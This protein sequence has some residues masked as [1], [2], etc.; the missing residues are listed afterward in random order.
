MI[1]V[2]DQRSGTVL[3]LDSLSAGT[4]FRRLTAGA[5]TGPMSSP[6]GLTATGDGRLLIADTGNNRVLLLDPAG[7]STASIE[8]SGSPIGPLHRPTCAAMTSSGRLVVA[9]AGGHRVVFRDSLTSG[10][11]S[12]YGTPGGSGPGGFEAPVSVCIDTSDRI[13][14]ADPG[15]DRLVRFD[16]PN[17]SGWTELALPAGAKP[18]RPYALGLGMGGVL[19]SD[20]VNSRILLLSGNGSVSVLID[21]RTDRSLIAPVG[22]AMLG[23]DVVVADA[24]TGCITRW[25]PGSGASPWSIVER[26]DGRG[27]VTGGPRFSSLSG[28]AIQEK[29]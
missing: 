12:A 6:S 14:V 17:G 25:T 10:I 15:A 4:P 19:V 16:A 11:W 5:P 7:G 9:D 29:P 26:L 28:L 20:L 23:S 24:A 27:G 2:V 13:V 1:Y 22:L 18:A 21:G 3:A 8:S